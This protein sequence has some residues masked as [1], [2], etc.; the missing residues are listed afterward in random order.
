MNDE[1]L[2][3]VVTVDIDPSLDEEFGKWYD[4][5]HLPD[6]LSCDG[7]TAAWRMRSPDTDQSP[8]YVSCYQIS[9]KSVLESAEVAAVRGWGPFESSVSNYKRLFFKKV[10]AM[11]AEEGRAAKA[12]R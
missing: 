11:T 12:K 5:V 9:D 3:L 1:G 2:L 7:F 10:T 8:R 4:E 6:I